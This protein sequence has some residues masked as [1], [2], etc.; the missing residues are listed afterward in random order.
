MKRYFIVGYMGA[1]KNYYGRWM[2][3]MLSLPFYDLDAYIRRQEKMSIE[4]IF[5][6]FGEGY[7]RKRERD[8]LRELSFVAENYVIATGGGTP[9]FYDNM[10]F[11]NKRGCTICLNTP[12]EIISRRLEYRRGKRPLLENIPQEA[13]YEYVSAHMKS[14]SSYYAK[15]RIQLYPDANGRFSLPERIDD[16]E[17]IK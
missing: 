8:Y 2:A 13:M 11:M 3:K 12:L 17:F 5:T 10:D 1:G 15:A 9:C 4:D 16:L 14:R 7:F 6:H